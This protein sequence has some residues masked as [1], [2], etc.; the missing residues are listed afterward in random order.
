MRH[1]AALLERISSQRE[2]LAELD[3]RLQP[4]FLSADRAVLAGRFLRAHSLLVAGLIGLAMVRRKGVSG[5]VK[6]AWR[7]WKAY[8]YL[9]DFSKKPTFHP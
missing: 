7:G 2:A 5:L 3:V 1:R 6:V 8:R 9:N 4:V